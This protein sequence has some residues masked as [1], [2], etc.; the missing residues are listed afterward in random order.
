MN[1][2]NKIPLDE[3]IINMIQSKRPREFIS[4]R[5]EPGL[6]EYFGIFVSGIPKKISFEKI[7][8]GYED[9]N[10]FV[11]MFRNTNIGIAY[12]IFNDESQRNKELSTLLNEIQEITKIPFSSAEEYNFN[13]SLQEFRQ[14]SRSFYDFNQKNVFTPHAVQECLKENKI[15]AHR[16]L[17]IN[18][19]KIKESLLLLNA[20]RT[21]TTNIESTEYINWIILFYMCWLVS[22]KLDIENYCKYSY[23]FFVFNHDCLE[24]FFRGLEQNSFKIK[25]LAFDILWRFL[26]LTNQFIHQNEV[27]DYVVILIIARNSVEVSLQ[28]FSRSHAHL[29]ENILESDIIKSL[30]KQFSDSQYSM[31]VNEFVSNICLM[32]LPLSIKGLTLCNRNVV[33]KILGDLEKYNSEPVFWGFTIMTA[34]HEFGHFAQMF[35]KKND[36][37]W[38]QH[39]T[40]R[41]KRYK[42]SE[43]G[44]ILVN[45]IFNYEPEEINES[46]SVFIMDLKNWQAPKQVFIKQFEDINIISSEKV[47]NG[48]TVSLRLKETK[49][50]QNIKAIKLGGCRFSYSRS[51]EEKKS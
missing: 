38:F 17:A 19:L 44:S 2:Y 40:P 20:T 36:A 15:I 51:L 28:N 12:F 26:F 50:E 24:M 47:V 31:M 37:D 3:I 33:I 35:N 13:Q 21:E 42:I 29:I 25:F 45:I 10:P 7:I 18:Y 27:I 5:A 11:P 43:A 46:A 23:F 14:I 1:F 6:K 34:I 32:N 9:H 49:V 22:F 8:K 30:F 39:Q 48:K 4:E 16:L 41:K